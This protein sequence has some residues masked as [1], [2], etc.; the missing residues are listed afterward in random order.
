MTLTLMMNEFFTPKKIK[1]MIL[2]L[3]AFAAMC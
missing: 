2:V 1:I 3:A